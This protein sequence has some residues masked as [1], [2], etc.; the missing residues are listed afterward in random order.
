MAEF[1]VRRD[2]DVVAAAVGDL[3]VVRVPENGGTG[4]QWSVAEV[5]A[6]LRI[7]GQRWESAGSALPGAGGE[8]VI[9]LR[10]VAPGVADVRLGLRR[11][12]EP[13]PVR[14]FSVRVEVS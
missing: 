2:G 11:V 9:E 12:W 3:V 7:D 14:S 8:R 10:A 5:G 1:E 6:P 13:D 4:Y